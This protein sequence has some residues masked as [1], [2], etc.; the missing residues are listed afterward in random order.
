MNRDDNLIL[1]FEG[2]F[3]DYFVEADVEYEGHE[4]W[5][6]CKYNTVTVGEAVDVE[7]FEQ[8]IDDND[9]FASGGWTE[10]KT[11]AYL[12]L[13]SQAIRD[14]SL[15][16][17]V[18]PTKRDVKKHPEYRKGPLPKYAMNRIACDSHHIH[19]EE[20]FVEEMV[21]AGEREEWLQKYAAEHLAYQ[22][23]M[24]LLAHR[25]FIDGMP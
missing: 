15:D 22:R 18:L 7:L 17:L 13:I 20:C 6:H 5:V 19:T 2:I 11:T 1:P 16:R 14:G 12:S 10:E 4:Y 21:S 23:F 3:A 24:E 8:H 9:G 25:R